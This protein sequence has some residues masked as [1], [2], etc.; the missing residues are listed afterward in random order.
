[1]AAPPNFPHDRVRF[2]A[3]YVH[4]WED[5]L[6]NMVQTIYCIRLY[7][8]PSLC[9]DARLIIPTS[10]FR[11][12]LRLQNLSIYIYTSWRQLGL[13]KFQGMQEWSMKPE[14]VYNCYPSRSPQLVDGIRTLIVFCA[15]WQQKIAA[16]GM[17]TFSSAKSILFQRHAALVMTNNAL[18]LM[19]GLVF[20]HMRRNLLP[21]LSTYFY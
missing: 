16:R 20:W 4:C 11:N 15:Q 12:T 5:F 1:M 7:V 17:S 14:E 18:C 10:T 6:M 19:S 21:H 2:A 8:L 13:D 9:V 3:F